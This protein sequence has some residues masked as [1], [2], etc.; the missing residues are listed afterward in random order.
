MAG[1]QTEV[2]DRLGGAHSLVALIDPHGPPD[3]DGFFLVDQFGQVCDLRGRQPREPLGGFGREL[4]H[5]V[6]E[7]LVAA[8][9][10]SDEGLVDPAVFDQ[11]VGQ[12]IKEGQVALGVRWPNSEWP[13]WLTP[14]A[15]GR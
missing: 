14:S 13:L 11:H 1:H 12:G 6:F 4:G 8:G 9:V 5:V 7:L 15:A 3:A 10:V 2:D